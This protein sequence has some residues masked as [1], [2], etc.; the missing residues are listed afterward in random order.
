M[1]E[2]DRSQHERARAALAKLPPELQMLH[3]R[4]LESSGMKAGH[5]PSVRA[6]REHQAE[7][8]A[9]HAAEQQ[10]HAPT[11]PPAR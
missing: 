10:Q 2:H 7:A 6:G 11:P 3:G 9:R 8:K 4:A 1:S 5:L